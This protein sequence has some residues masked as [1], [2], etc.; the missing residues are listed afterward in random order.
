MSDPAHRA[1]SLRRFVLVGALALGA[2][3]LGVAACTP[4][5]HLDSPPAS[6]VF[7]TAFSAGLDDG[8]KGVIADAAET[9]R[10]AP[11]VRVVVQGFADAVG[12]PA[13]NMTLSMLRAQVVADALV[14][15]G[16]ERGRIALR[17]RGA[18]L[19]DPGIESRRVEI[20]FAR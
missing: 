11:T 4:M 2:L 3:T 1:V 15:R 17:P 16:V 12:T 7:F 10:S 5:P 19:A 8:A 18:T 14:A 20:T 9:A 6:V 13:A